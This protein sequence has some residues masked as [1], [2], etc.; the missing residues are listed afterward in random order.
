MPGDQLV[1]VA[2]TLAMPRGTYEEQRARLSRPEPKAAPRARVRVSFEANG[3]EHGAESVTA[4]IRSDVGEPLSWRELAASDMSTLV[5]ASEKAVRV[6]LDME[7][8]AARKAAEDAR[9]S[10]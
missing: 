8:F 9:R 3:G 5:V 2:E 4:D 10:R 7:G 6:I 1:A